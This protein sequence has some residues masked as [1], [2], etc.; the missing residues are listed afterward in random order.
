MALRRN[1]RTR[2]CEFCVGSGTTEEHI[3]PR[4]WAP[5][6]GMTE[7]PP[8]GQSFWLVHGVHDPIGD[9][10]AA[11]LI[12][13]KRAKRPAMT[14]RAFCQACQGGWMRELDEAV[15][16]MIEALTS[17]Q[18]ITLDSEQQATLA[19]WAVK[20]ILAFCTKESRERQ[21][22]FGVVD[23]YRRFGDMRRPLPGMHVWLGQRLQDGGAWFRPFSVTLKDDR[24]RSIP[25]L[26]AI[27]AIRHMVAYM[28]GPADQPDVRI[29]FRYEP[30]MALKPIFPGTGK[31]LSFPR[32]LGI[33]ASDLTT[34]AKSVGRGIFVTVPA[35]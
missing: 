33:A 14:T 30:A 8:Q 20:T 22:E 18:D 7:S 11:R 29:R 27:L 24:G 10:P 6:F 9:G 34:L 4:S 13:E 3:L 5:I 16:P 12:D 23:I 19:A 2:K 35:A 15:R 26:G 21:R 31:S 28:L 17:L 1:Q 32:A 25:G